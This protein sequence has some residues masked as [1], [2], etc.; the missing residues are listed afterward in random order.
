MRVVGLDVSAG[1]GEEGDGIVVVVG[2][3]ILLV[4]CI[5]FGRLFNVDI[6]EQSI[7]VS[8]FLCPFFSFLY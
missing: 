5:V 2:D 7:L 8:D 6:G 1:A 4:K 3:D